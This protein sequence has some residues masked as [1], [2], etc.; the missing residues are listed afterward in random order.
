MRVR[1]CWRARALTLAMIAVISGFSATAVAKRRTPPPPPPEPPACDAPQPSYVVFLD[2][3][4]TGDFYLAALPCLADQTVAPVTTQRLAL[5]LPR[6]EQRKF[7]IANG[8]VF[9]DGAQRRIVFGGRT[10]PS[11]YWGIYEGVLDVSRGMISGI[12]AV[13]STPFVREEDP[14]FSSDGQWIVY[15]RDGEIWRVYADDPSAEPSRFYREDGC[16]L[17]AP[18]MFANVVAYTR[19]CDGVPESDRIVYHIDGGARFILPSDGGGP[20]RFA[21]FTR[22]GELVYSHVDTSNNTAGLW[23]YILGSNPFFL[24]QQTTSDD[25]AFAERNGDE[26]IAFSGWGSAGYDLYVYRRTLRTAVQLTS[27][28]NVLGSILFD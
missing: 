11:E 27:G 6:R 3:Y 2:D 1:Y 15:K 9:F 20:D 21:H 24:H 13:V 8:D 22:A 16:E 5:D 23:M 18:S 17:W 7:Q 28:I 4:P 25:D 26:Y 14:R 10:G 12:N 19:R